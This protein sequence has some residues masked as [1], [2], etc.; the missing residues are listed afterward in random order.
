MMEVPNLDSDT[1]TT[2]VRATSKDFGFL[3][4]HFY[5]FDIG[6]FF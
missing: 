6:G 4:S 3:V 1:I 2:H 5:D